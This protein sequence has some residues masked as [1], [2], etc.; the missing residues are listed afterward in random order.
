MRIRP[1]L[2][3]ADTAL[4]GDGRHRPINPAVFALQYRRE[5][6]VFVALW[7]RFDVLKLFESFT[8]QVSACFRESLHQFRR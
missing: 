6:R 7:F 2:K 4:D 1:G 8:E 5:R 3:A